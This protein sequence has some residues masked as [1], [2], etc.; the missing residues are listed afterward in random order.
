MMILT[1]EEFD[2]CTYAQPGK[3]FSGFAVMAEQ[4]H[5]HHR[6]AEYAGERQTAHGRVVAVKPLNRDINGTPEWEVLERSPERLQV[7]DLIEVMYLPETDA[8]ANPGTT[9]RHK[10][11]GPA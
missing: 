2:R 1:V 9:A 7:G 6:F 4:F 10:A 3:P 5:I 11:P 8:N